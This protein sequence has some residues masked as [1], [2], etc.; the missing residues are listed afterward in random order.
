MS[1]ILVLQHVPH[2]RLGTLEAPLQASGHTLLPLDAYDAK[3]QWPPLSQ[4]DGLVI[5]GGPMSVTQQ[6]KHPFLGRELVLIREALLKRLPMLGV[7]LGAQL[8]AAALDARVYAALHKEIGWFPVMREPG[9]EQDPLMKSFHSTETV[10][11][12][13]GDTFDLPRGAKRLASSPLCTEQGFRYR[14]NV[15]A[16]QFHLEMTE[17]M[18]RAWMR[19]PVNRTELA[20]LKGIVDPLAVRRQS[21][22]HVGRL[23]Q[24][25]DRV[26]KAFGRLVAMGP[27]PK[28]A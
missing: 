6:E 20:G 9:M 24:L 7:C 13:H 15:Y 21:P 11:Q 18:V 12:W 27:D 5:M 3:A 17:A 16:L 8:L 28:A 22:R 25:A 2:E 19:T 10:F 26:A 14:D 23:R 4:V 1:R